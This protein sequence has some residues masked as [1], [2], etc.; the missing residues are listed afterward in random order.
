M[1]LKNRFSS[2][3]IV[4]LAANLFSS[5]GEWLKVLVVVVQGFE[6]PVQLVGNASGPH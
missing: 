5:F 2:C 1:Q 3:E 4:R 6:K